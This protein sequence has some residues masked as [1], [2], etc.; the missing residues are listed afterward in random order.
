[1]SVDSGHLKREHLNVA[2]DESGQSYRRVWDVGITGRHVSCDVRLSKA[3]QNCSFHCNSAGRA[4]KGMTTDR[5]T[6]VR[7]RKKLSCIGLI[8]LR[9]LHCRRVL[10]RCLPLK[11]GYL[12]NDSRLYPSARLMSGTKWYGSWRHGDLPTQT[13]QWGHWTCLHPLAYG[14][15]QTLFCNASSRD[16]GVAGWFSADVAALGTAAIWQ[17]LWSMLTGLLT[18]ATFSWHSRR[19]DST[20]QKFGI[21]TNGKQTK[22][23]RPGWNQRKFG[24]KRGFRRKT[25]GLEA[26][27]S[28]CMRGGRG[29]A[30]TSGK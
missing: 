19:L 30:L 4:L 12:Q 6:T 9:L 29:L 23:E 2:L 15:V 16:W 20:I 5:L 28:D 18:T 27:L 22:K 17:P 13:Y 3:F 21:K 26:S 8:P 7:I 25:V 24:S 1:M 11:F 10:W 14:P